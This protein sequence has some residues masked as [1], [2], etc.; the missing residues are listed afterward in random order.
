[1]ETS[2]TRYAL[3]GDVHIAYR[4]FGSGPPDL[5]FASGLDFP[6]VEFHEEFSGDD[7]GELTDRMRVIRYDKRGTGQSG[8]TYESYAPYE[9]NRSCDVRAHG[10]SSLRICTSQ[11]QHESEPE[12]RQ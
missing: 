6:S 8:G 3:S 1:M 10:V 12:L 7:F 4:V 5:V 2:D 11:V 9:S